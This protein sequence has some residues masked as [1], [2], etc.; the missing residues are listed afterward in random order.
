MTS[1]AAHPPA[2][3]HDKSN[4]FPDLLLRAEPDRSELQAAGK[5][6]SVPDDTEDSWKLSPKAG[7][8]PAG[9]MLMLVLPVGFRE[10]NFLAQIFPV[11][12]MILAVSMQCVELRNLVDS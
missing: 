2:R 11:H 3:S 10:A 12:F 6:V 8:F 5:Q 9:K 7:S 4:R 1:F